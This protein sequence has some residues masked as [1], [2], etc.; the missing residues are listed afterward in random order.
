MKLALEALYI[1]KEYIGIG[2]NRVIGNRDI[3]IG[4]RNRYLKILDMKVSSRV[5]RYRVIGIKDN[6]KTV[7]GNSVLATQSIKARVR[8]EGCMQAYTIGGLLTRI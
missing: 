4:N 8:Q 6:S 2:K 1:Y 7:E 5:I 3:V